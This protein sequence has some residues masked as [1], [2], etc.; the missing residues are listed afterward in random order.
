[1]TDS[2]KLTISGMNTVIFLM[3]IWTILLIV[4]YF[5]YDSNRFFR[6]IGDIFI[7]ISFVKR[8]KK[9]LLV[10]A[11]IPFFIGLMFLIFRLMM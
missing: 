6:I 4:T 8:T 1:M 3:F 2:I 5:K 7:K 9:D 11:V 10:F